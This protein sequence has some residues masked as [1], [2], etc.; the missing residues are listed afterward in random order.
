M[1]ARWIAVGRDHRLQ[2]AVRTQRL[3]RR[4]G[5]EQHGK[6]HERRP[7]SR[8]LEAKQLSPAAPLYTLRR[9][10]AVSA[11][12]CAKLIQHLKKH[13][14]DTPSC[15]EK[16]FSDTVDRWSDQRRMTL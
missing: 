14:P 9:S 8:R 7:G 3:E 11:W 6:S 10:I 5:E 12:N 4:T 16:T 1:S 15:G 2:Q 13:T